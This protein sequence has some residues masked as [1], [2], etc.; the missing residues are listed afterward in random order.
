MTLSCSQTH[1]QTQGGAR[2]SA[3]GPSLPSHP[4]GEMGKVNEQELSPSSPADTPL[5]HQCCW[6][7]PCPPPPS[8]P[9][10]KLF[11][12]VHAT[13]LARTPHAPRARLHVFP[14]TDTTSQGPAAPATCVQPTPLASN[15]GNAPLWPPPHRRGP[16][17]LLFLSFLT[18]HPPPRF[19][20]HCAPRSPGGWGSQACFCL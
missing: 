5:S 6:G 15:P 1:L 16:L 7:L 20:H 19:P 11:S 8:G 12:S 2:A 3:S 9:V 18:V 13:P 4:R 14:T 17:R 10:I